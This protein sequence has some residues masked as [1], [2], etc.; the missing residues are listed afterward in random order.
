MFQRKHTDENEW[1]EV[2]EDVMRERL[3]GYFRDVNKAILDLHSGIV[4]RTPWALWRWIAIGDK[5]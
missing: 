3:A 1:R 2:D 5:H 4:L